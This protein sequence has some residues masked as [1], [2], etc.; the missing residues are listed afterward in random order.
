MQQ[1]LFPCAGVVFSC[2]RKL[3]VKLMGCDQGVGSKGCV[4]V[5]EVGPALHKR[6]HLTWSMGAEQTG[7]HIHAYKAPYKDF[8]FKN[9]LPNIL[10]CMYNVVQILCICR[11][12]INHVKELWPMCIYSW[13]CW[14]D[15]FPFVSTDVGQKKMKFKMLRF[16]SSDATKDKSTCLVKIINLCAKDSIPLEMPFRRI[17]SGVWCR[18]KD[19]SPRRRDRQVEFD[20]GGRERAHWGSVPNWISRQIQ[21]YFRNGFREWIRT[22]GGCF[23]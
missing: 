16:F 10:Y 11:L 1:E 20:P 14:H 17:R 4:G 22:V 2:L 15:H 23:F 7:I 13:D 5:G 21:I 18:L 19:T 12:K 6:M 3:C 8:A 9:P